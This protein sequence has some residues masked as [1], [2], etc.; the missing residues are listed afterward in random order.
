MLINKT[1]NNK[2]AQYINSYYVSGDSVE[3]VSNK[4]NKSKAIKLL[5]QKFNVDTK[6]IYTIG[7]GFSDI[8][9]VK[10]FSGY[11]MEDSVEEL[12]KETKKAYK[13]VSELIKEVMEK[14]GL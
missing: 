6:N 5:T 2:Y 11:C 3:V 1:L 13:S 4:T 14:K 12:K 9:M 8:E 10:D 7:D